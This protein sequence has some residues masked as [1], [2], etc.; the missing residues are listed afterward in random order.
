KTNRLTIPH[1]RYGRRLFVLLPLQEI[2]P[3]FQCPLTGK[4]I[5]E[6]A[7]ALVPQQAVT[8]ISSRH[9]VGAAQ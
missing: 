1:P 7:D 4:T 6:M 5:K 9:V 8:R 3:A 2:A